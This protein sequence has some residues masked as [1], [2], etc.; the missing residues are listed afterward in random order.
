MT[1][2]C[3][4]QQKEML[5]EKSRDRS[6]SMHNSDFGELIERFEPGGLWEGKTHGIVPRS[7]TLSDTFRALGG[8]LD[9]LTIV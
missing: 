7:W 8:L 1:Y 4:I 5:T 3:R 9:W 2:L 6:L